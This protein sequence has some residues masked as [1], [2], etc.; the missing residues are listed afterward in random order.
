M[1]VN[2]NIYRT[3][4]RVERRSEKFETIVALLALAAIGI[5][6]GLIERLG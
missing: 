4:R 6:Y 2:R 1:A 3:G 5:I